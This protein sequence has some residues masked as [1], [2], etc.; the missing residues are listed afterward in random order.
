MEKIKKI[1]ILGAS[2]S[3][4]GAAILAKSKGYNV[5]VSDLGII[6]DKYKQELIKYGIN[7]E[8]NKHSLEILLSYNTIIKSPGIPN[9]SDII[10]AIKNQNLQLLSEIEFASR[11]TNAK[12]IGITGTTGKTTTASLVYY[13]LQE[14][15]KNVII[16]GN[17]GYSFARALIEK[18]Q[19][20]YYVLELSSFQLEDIK[21]FKSDIAIIL[22]ITEDHLDIHKTMN[23]YLKCKFN[24]IKNQN[25]GDI[26]IYNADDELIN[27]FLDNHNIKSRKFPMSLKTDKNVLHDGAI[28]HGDNI[29]LKNNSQEEYINTN[30][31][32][33]YGNHNM[34]NSMAAIIA[35]RLYEVKSE[36]LKQSL[37]SFKNIDHRLE[38]V[39]TIKGIQ[40]INDSKAT[41]INATWYAL[42]STHT[43]IILL[44]GGVDKGNDYSKIKDLVKNKV[45]IIINLTKDPKQ[46]DKL[47]EYFQ[48]YVD[49]INAF[50]MQEA[51]KIS[52]EIASKG[53]T[54]LLSPACAS[55]DLFK[56]YQDRGKQFKEAVL[57]L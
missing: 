8:E 6:N 7:Y 50:S 26:F 9:K 20:D 18:P 27:T 22:N 47:H 23:E 24:I 30:N 21:N 51:V 44:M 15:G 14:A 48:D 56:S 42:E 33:L 38:K 40:F 2:E 46:R 19:A 57:K 52:Y 25:I 29:I 12:I 4:L 28:K 5:F 41:N 1:A 31:F 49:V 10:K 34:Y 54:V 36:S 55:F 13:I 45:K 17:I 37:Q 39:A 53:D 3:G 32:A 35:A 11:F 16:A 43:K